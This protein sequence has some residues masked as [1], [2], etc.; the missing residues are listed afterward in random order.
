MREL[1]DINFEL[2]A[3]NVVVA[4]FGIG[5]H[6]ARDAASGSC[7]ALRHAVERL[8]ADEAGAAAAVRR[9]RRP[10]ARRR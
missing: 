6:A 8:G 2:F 1:D 7:A 10:G 5:E 3:E 9:R 4:V